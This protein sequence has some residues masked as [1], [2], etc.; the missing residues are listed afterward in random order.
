MLVARDRNDAQVLAWLA[1]WGA[2]YSCPECSEPVYVRDPADRVTHFCHYPDSSCSYG[3]GEGERHIRMKAAVMA[4]AA[5]F[6]DVAFEKQELPELLRQAHQAVSAAPVVRSSW[7]I[8][9]QQAEEDAELGEA[10]GLAG[11]WAPG[12]ARVTDTPLSAQEQQGSPVAVVP[13]RAIQ[14]HR[15]GTK[16]GG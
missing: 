14:Q 4:E 6:P 10:R 11:G 13:E 7:Q 12:N 2:E 16:K 3:V 1:E 9:G 8:Q 5:S 15:K